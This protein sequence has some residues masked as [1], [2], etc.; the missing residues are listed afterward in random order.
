[1]VGNSLLRQKTGI[2]MGIEPA[3]FWANLFLYTYEKEYT[4]QFISNDKVKARHFHATK[5]FIDD[6]GTL[7]D[8]DVFNGVYKDI[9]PPELQL[10]VEHSGTHARFF[11][12]DIT[13]KDGLFV[14]KLFDK[15]D[16]VPFFIV[17]LS[18]IDS[19]IPK[20]IIYSA[21]VVEFL[22]IAR[23]SLLYKDFNEKGMELLNRKKAQGAQS[24]RCRKAL[25]KI[26]YQFCLIIYQ[27]W[28]KL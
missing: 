5:L 15:C 17:R 3:P 10:K 12:L 24:L 4:S 22:R 2:P 21:L 26:V 23:S 6:L 16:A 19:D 14:Y 28:K 9:Y 11:N 1:M 20:S 7:N 27:F 25:S 13:V 18:Y 8:E